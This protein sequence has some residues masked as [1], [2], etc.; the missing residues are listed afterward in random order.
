MQQDIKEISQ[1]QV[2]MFN[3]VKFMFSTEKIL[4]LE[5]NLLKLLCVQAQYQLYF[6][7]VHLEVPTLWMEVQSGMST[8]HPQSMVV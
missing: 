6:N 4:L 1:L 7:H 3:P 5:M 2:L 8:S